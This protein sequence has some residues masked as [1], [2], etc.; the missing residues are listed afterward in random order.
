MT[1][2]NLEVVS[3]SKPDADHIADFLDDLA[4]RAREG[5]F[6]TVYVMGFQARS[7][8]WFT[9]ERGKRH[10]RL[11]MIGILECLKDDLVRAQD[12]NQ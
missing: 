10:S 9:M 5:E 11:E 3:L 7:G 6:A 1:G 12:V 2:R 8:E 4:R